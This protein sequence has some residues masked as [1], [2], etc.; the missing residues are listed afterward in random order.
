MS[1]APSGY[2]A[3]KTNWKSAD[4]PLPTDLNRIEGNIQA[5]ES[6]S[7]TLDPSQVPSGNTGSLRQLLDWFANRIKAI[8]GTTNWYDAPATTL[9]AAKSHIDATSGIH[10]A[11]SSATANRIIIR[12]SAGRAKVAPPQAGDD[13]ARKDTVD[14]HANATSVHGATSS[15]TANRLVARDANGRAKFASPASAGDAVIFPVPVTALKLATGTFSANP[16]TYQVDVHR[17]AFASPL[18]TTSGSIAPGAEVSEIGY[19]TGSSAM[20]RWMFRNAGEYGVTWTWDYVTASGQPRVWAEVDDA[21]N[22]YAM[23]E[24]EDPADPEFPDEPPFEPHPGRVLVPLDAPGEAILSAVNA[25]LD[26]VAIPQVFARSIYAT[27]S[28]HQAVRALLADQLR[29]RALE[30][31]DDIRD[32]LT[33]ADRDRRHWYLQLYFRQASRVLCNHRASTLIPLYREMC[34]VNLKTGKLEL[35]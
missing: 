20:R 4:V 13:I 30:E 32:V 15:A 27:S 12:D 19:L 16:G 5:I 7:R 11:T 31:P 10:G 33:I 29:V 24:A 9:A 17:Y 3:P 18:A 8:T 21:G 34:R 2:Q 14:A 1:S 22:I 28:P 26:Q 23:W 6:G 35:W 25:R